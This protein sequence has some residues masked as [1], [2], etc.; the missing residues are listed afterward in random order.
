[1][2]GNIVFIGLPDVGKTYVGKKLAE[3]SQRQFV[4]TDQEMIK[5]VNEKMSIKKV[6]EFLGTKEFRRQEKEI[7]LS[8]D[9][10]ENL[11]IST[12]GGV[13]EIDDAKDLLRKLGHVVYLRIDKETIKASWLKREAFFISKEKMDDFYDRRVKLYFKICHQQLERVWD[14]IVLEGSLKSHHL[15]SPMAKL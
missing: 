12:G 4:D 9:S 6:Q 3:A 7:L 2:R 8:L 15:G 5:R 11:V 14:Q 1:M 10:I 13:V